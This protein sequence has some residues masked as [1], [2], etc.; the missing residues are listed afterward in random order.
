MIVAAAASG[1]I[2]SGCK[3]DSGGP[4]LLQTEQAVWS[5]AAVASWGER[6]CDGVMQY[7]PLAESRD[8]L[9]RHLP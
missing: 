1:A 9:N 7:A 8:F 5:L 6:Y 4:L 2:A 3:G